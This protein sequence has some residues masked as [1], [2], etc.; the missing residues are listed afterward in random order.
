MHN[1]REFG[2][3]GDGVTKDTGAIQKAID[4]G[5]MVCF[6]PGV[7]LSGSLYLKSNGGLFLE[8]G[9]VLLASPDKEDYNAD[10]FCEQN[11]PGTSE[12]ASGAHF[13]IALE[14]EN[15]V[16][17]GGGRIDGNRKSF[18]G[19]DREEDCTKG[20]LRK[21]DPLTGVHYVAYEKFGRREDISW[22]PAQMIYICES[23]NIQIRD[24]QLDDAPYWTCFLHGCEDVQIRGLRILNDQRGH[25]TDGID[26]DC[27]R[28]V[29]I[30]DCII[31][32]G[33]DC[34]T[35]R[36]NDRKL[37]NKRPCEY[38]TVTN[39]VLHSCANGIRIG[40]GDGIIRNA[41]FS[42]IVFHHCGTAVNICSNFSTDPARGAEISRISMVNLQMEAMRAFL[43]NCQVRGST[44][45]EPAKE[46]RDIHIRQVRGTVWRP[47]LICG[48]AGKGMK[49][50]VLED[51]ELDI[52]TELASSDNHL[53]P[54]GEFGSS[55]P[56]CV[57]YIAHAEGVRLERFKVNWKKT[58][59]GWTYGVLTCNSRN[60]EKNFVSLGRPDLDVDG[61]GRPKERQA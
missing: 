58:V 6:P 36:G 20:P 40:V 34:I 56:E 37:K 18:Y 19:E 11:S 15:I 14:Q 55:N 53:G 51:V 29:N 25:N 60:V 43:I 32:S 41:V 26:I 42:N 38:V 50:I 24:L 33:D 35:L 12:H 59:G 31:D 47:C 16:L 52:E 30:S 9:A 5:G 49:D 13:L 17:C 1:V 23:R 2:A 4:A 21:T 46:V 39:C 54:W 57:I 3:K 48:S 45:E 8:P 61:S 44:P 10:D 28:R 27:C 22:R 7:Y